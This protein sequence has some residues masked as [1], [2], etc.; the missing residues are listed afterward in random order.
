[1]Y[2]KILVPLDGSDLAEAALPHART[3]AQCYDA[4]IVLLRVPVPHLREHPPTMGQL[5]PDAIAQ[6]EELVQ[7][8]IQDY[9]ERAAGPFHECG[10]RVNIEMRAGH[11][12]DA[13]LDVADEGGV[14]LIVMSTHGR[15]GLSRW[16]IGSV[17]NKVVHG[18]K[19]PVL[20]VR[21]SEVSKPAHDGMT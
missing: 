4:E 20:L 2:K 6:Q 15:S 13:I 14:D 16:L 5:F 10:V 17:A 12:A 3:L 11:V 21:P 1:M 18:A 8:H 9:L 19:V 7:Q